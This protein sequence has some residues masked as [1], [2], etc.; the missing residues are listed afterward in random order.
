MVLG[1]CGSPHVLLLPNVHDQHLS[2]PLRSV[3][4]FDNLPQP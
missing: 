2:G 3:H 4:V 1:T